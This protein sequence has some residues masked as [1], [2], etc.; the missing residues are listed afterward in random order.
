MCKESGVKLENEYWLD[1][2]PKLVETNHDCNVTIWNQKCRP[3]EP[4]VK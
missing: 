4:S 1:H 2:L 3:T